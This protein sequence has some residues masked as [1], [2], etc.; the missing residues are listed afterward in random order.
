MNIEDFK[1]EF[2]KNGF[3]VVQNCISSELLDQAKDLV[4]R[5]LSKVTTKNCGLQD[6]LAEV[7]KMHYLSDIQTLILKELQTRG[8]RKKLLLQ[9]LVLEKLI[10]LIGPDLTYLRTSTMSINIKGQTDNLYR[11]RWHQEMWSG[12]GLND[13]MVWMPLFMQKGLGG[14]Q[15]IPASHIWGIIPNRNR[16]PTELP[17]DAKILEAEVKEGDAILFHSLTLHRTVPNLSEVPRVAFASTVRN[18][19]HVFTGTEQLNSWTPFHYSPYARIR[20]MLG[21]PYLTPF[22]TL[23]GPLSNKDDGKQDLPGLD[24]CDI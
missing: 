19:N 20:K 7:T 12:G 8:I 6:S 5:C 2:C 4:L 14:L 16:E 22:R 9:P 24:E 18:F 23:G 15:F 21:N 11:K 10:H 3:V 17:S 13:V 1:E